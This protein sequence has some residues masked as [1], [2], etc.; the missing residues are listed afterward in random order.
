MNYLWEC[1]FIVNFD[2]MSA[3]TIIVS[4]EEIPEAIRGSWDASSRLRN[5]TLFSIEGHSDSVADFVESA[6]VMSGAKTKEDILEVLR[7]IA[8]KISVGAKHN[9]F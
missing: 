3:D 7:G 2:Q 6:V 8:D 9:M 1:I 4:R 5:G